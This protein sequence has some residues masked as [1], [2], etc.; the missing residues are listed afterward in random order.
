MNEI[1]GPIIAITLV[2]SSVFLPS[3]FLGG[4][5]G[6]FFRQFGL[7][8]ACATLFSLVVSFSVT[9]MLAS[10]WLRLDLR[11]DAQ[12]R[13][14]ILERMVN[15]FYGPIERGYMNV[16]EGPGLGVQVNETKVAN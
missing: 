2:L 15:G 12:R 1:T 7:T 10:R 8:V 6:Q 9:P 4:I 3:A 14:S 5:T 16:P 13:K 11:P